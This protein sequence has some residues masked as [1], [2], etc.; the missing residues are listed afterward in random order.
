MTAP[1]TLYTFED[2]N[3]TEDSYSTQ[4]IADA[5][6]YAQR[7]DRALIANEY[8]WT[9]SE[10]IEDYTTAPAEESAP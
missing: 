10:L 8:E 4:D 1:I 5:R 3:G 9:D 6:E 7:Y 2:E